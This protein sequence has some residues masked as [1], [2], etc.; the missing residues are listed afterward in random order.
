[1]LRERYNARSDTLRSTWAT[2]SAA[3]FFLAETE[4]YL[5]TEVVAG[6]WEG[7]QRW[8]TT[9]TDEPKHDSAAG[10]ARQPLAVSSRS[11][12]VS[13]RP[14]APSG[15][16]AG[17]G[18]DAD[19][20]ADESDIWLTDKPAAQPQNAPPTSSSRR[21]PPL[22]PHDPQTLAVAHR[23]YLRA[24]T[25]RLLLTQQPFA[26]ALYVLLVHTDHL[27]ALVHRLQGI[28]AALD[29]EADVGV[30]DAFVDLEREEREVRR[31][32]GRVE[33]RVREGVAGAVAE[34]RVLEADSE[35]FENMV[36]GGGGGGGGDG[37][38]D[39]EEGD[40]SPAVELGGGGCRGVGEGVLGEAQGRYVPRRVGGVDRLLMKL[41]FGSWFDAGRRGGVASDDA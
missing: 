28:W 35:A 37:D 10:N 2:C 11:P 12:A 5:Q 33:A 25:R 18:A 32:M 23:A 3:I 36:G 40:G 31:D 21:P 7:F 13:S 29:L 8:L 1:M 15:D 41:D 16:D 39:A 14:P 26:D 9:G 19:A 34:L 27:V 17:A 38:G 22:P 24:L 20:D 6:L 4:A 30:V